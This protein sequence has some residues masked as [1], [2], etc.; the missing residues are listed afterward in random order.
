MNEAI[1]RI[2]NAALAQA[3]PFEKK[4]KVVLDTDQDEIDVA[5][6]MVKAGFGDDLKT[7]AIKNRFCRWDI[8]GEGVKA[9]I[10]SR[11][12]TKPEWD[13]WVIDTYKIDWM[14]DNHPDDELYFINVYDGKYHLYTMAYVSTCKKV[15][16]YA[17]FKDGKSGLRE[18]Y[19]IPKDGWLMELASGETNHIEK[20]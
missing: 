13:T 4:Q 14:M 9:E 6:M 15:K 17:R 5:G 19:E 11:T 12:Y 1:K 16:K 8:E 2:K 3:S 20:L 18:Y 10:K 7:T